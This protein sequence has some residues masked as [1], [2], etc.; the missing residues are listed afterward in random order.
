M[1]GIL[2][3]P[4]SPV[5]P[6]EL[7]LELQ[8]VVRSILDPPCLTCPLCRTLAGARACSAWYPG[9]SV[10]PVLS[11]ELPLELQPG[12]PGILDPPVSPVLSAELPLELEPVVPGILDPLSHLS[13][14]QNS[15]WSSSL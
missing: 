2:D 11:A 12:V 5:L 9:P 7:P 4:V 6:A 15:R 10:S 14:L 3:P 1:R 13:S 8:P